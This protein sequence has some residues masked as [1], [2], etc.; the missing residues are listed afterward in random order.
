MSKWDQ[1]VCEFAVYN[2]VGSRALQMASEKR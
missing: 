2:H 1:M